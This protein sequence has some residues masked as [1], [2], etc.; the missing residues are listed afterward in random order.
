MSA[1][2]P[3]ADMGWQSNV[4]FVPQGHSLFKAVFEIRPGQRCLKFYDTGV[5]NSASILVGLRG[6]QHGSPRNV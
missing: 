4:R 3:K 1:L 2:S 5:R 6:F